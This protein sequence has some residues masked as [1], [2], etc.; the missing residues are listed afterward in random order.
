MSGT[1]PE[2]SLQHHL[3]EEL[4]M[5]QIPKFQLVSLHD[6]ELWPKVREESS[7]AHLEVQE[8]R[9]NEAQH[10]LHH[11]EELLQAQGHQTHRPKE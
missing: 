10:H 9:Q 2:A 7:E 5:V 3:G 8:V 1:S 11:P 4:L 6:H